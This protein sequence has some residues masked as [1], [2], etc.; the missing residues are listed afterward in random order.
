MQKPDEQSIPKHSFLFWLV[1]PCI[2]VWLAFNYVRAATDTNYRVAPVEAKTTE[3]NIEVFTREFPDPPENING[4]VTL[5][6]DDAWM[7]QYTTAAPLLKEYGFVGTMAVPTK[8][9]ETQDYANWGQ[10]QRLQKEG[11]EITN[12]SQTHDCEMHNWSK[13]DI[14]NEFIRATLELWSKE[15]TSDIFV[16]PCGVT[17]AT[18]VREAKT[19]FAAFRGVSPG[20]NDLANLDPYQLSIK[21]I[22]M[23]TT[24]DELTHLLV[25]TKQSKGWLIIVF[26]KVGEDV[27]AT[28]DEL[29]NIELEDF[30]LLLEEIKLREIPVVTPSQLLKSL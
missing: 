21:N 3:S 28:E 26:H 6:F 9:I 12:H 17:S 13:A 30:K 18:L 25:S 20:I 27:E 19:H 10:V 8:A 1:I 5:W 14:K 24:L 29:Y 15:L 4:Y 23:N 16:S 2:V 11:W 7:S 22:D